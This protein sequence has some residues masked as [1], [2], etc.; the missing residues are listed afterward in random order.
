MGS[1]NVDNYADGVTFIYRYSVE[2]HITAGGLQDWLRR[3][4][5]VALNV[6]PVLNKWERTLSQTSED[7]DGINESSEGKI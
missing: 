6:S 1:I 7:D 2:K 3:Y 4:T 5:L